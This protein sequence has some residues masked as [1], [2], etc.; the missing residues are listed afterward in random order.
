MGRAAI[1]VMRHTM[2]RWAA[3]LLVLLAGL[4]DAAI[5]EPGGRV[6][7]VIGNGAYQNAPPLPNPA[8][9]ARAVAAALR[10]LDFQVIEAVDLDHPDGR[11]LITT[12]PP[13]YALHRWDGRTLVSHYEDV[14][15]WHALAHY[16]DKLQPMIH[17]MFGERE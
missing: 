17:E 10:G 9:D 6:A 15:G 16:T 7:L 5:A 4:A 8:N 13:S 3:L 2:A 12:E 11:D 14:S 1:A